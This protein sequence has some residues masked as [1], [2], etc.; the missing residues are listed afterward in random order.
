M[1]TEY[2]QNSY[3]Y[4]VRELMI[5]QFNEGADNKTFQEGGSVG[6]HI[7]CFG[8]EL[9]EFNEAMAAY[10][11]NPAPHTRAAMIKEWADVQVTLSNLSWFFSFDAEEAYNRVAANNL[12]K[13]VDGKLIKREDG[14][15]LKPEGYQK[16]DM[17]G[18]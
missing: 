6:M 11:A 1:N 2:Y 5:A 18:L 14:K 12:T 3:S 8:E 13:L 17:G 15:V 10:V 7:T 4:P 16:P 9:S